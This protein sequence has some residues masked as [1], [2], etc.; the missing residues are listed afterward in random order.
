MKILKIILIFIVLIGGIFLALNW[1]SLFSDKSTAEIGDDN[2]IDTTEECDEIRKA[3]DNTDKWNLALYEDQKSAIE[4]KNI[5]H[6]Y[7]EN[8]FETV[9]NTLKECAISKASESYKAVLNDPSVYSEAL[10]SDQYNGVLRLINDFN[11]SGDK[12]IDDVK[13][14]HA[15]Y[16]NALQ[17]TKSDHIVTPVFDTKTHSWESLVNKRTKIINQAKAI[18]SD[19]NYQFIQN[20]PGFSEKLDEED[21]TAIINAQESQFY[22]ELASQIVTHYR[23]R[24]KACNSQSK[25][26]GSLLKEYDTKIGLPFAN[27]T[28]FGLDTIKDF[29]KELMTAIENAT[30]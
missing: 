6:R 11:I 12:R 26:L 16:T 8:S 20:V 21:V 7:E 4:Q 15:L 5:S 3:W 22:N 9:M 23:A 24:M 1:D 29:Q 17:F 19:P 27:Q 14:I 10:L 13:A 18:T 2:I 28:T 25:L 30:N